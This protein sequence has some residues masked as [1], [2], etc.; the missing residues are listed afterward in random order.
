MT[1]P[2]E[3]RPKQQIPGY[4]LLSKL[5]SGA[6]ASV[7]KARQ[8]SLDRIVAI[9]VLPR[10]STADPSF[11]ERFY[12]EGRVAAKLNHPN[13]VGALD[14]GKAGDLHYFVMEY[15]EG[16]TVYDELMEN[17]L[18]DET[19]AV[20]IVLEIA[21]A[22]DHAHKAG[23]IHRDVKPQNIIIT[24]DGTA[25]LADMG[26]AREVGAQVNEDEAGKAVGSPYYM[27]PEQVVSDPRLDFRT[28]LYSIGA[29]FYFMVTG[30]V[31]FD[32]PTPKE[33]MQMHLND[34]LTPP[35]KAN[36]KVS[37][38][39]SEVIQVCMA[40]DPADRYDT[41]ADLVEDLEAI[42]AGEAPLKAQLKLGLNMDDDLG[43]MTPPPATRPES[44]M[45][46]PAKPKPTPAAN[47][48]PPTLPV[49]LHHQPMFW[50]AA[51][52]W[53]SAAVF[54]TLWWLK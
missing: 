37:Q 17:V 18:Y 38:E 13:I 28:D 20:R 34:D 22:L 12:A 43:D 26:L 32:A 47:R 48:K 36:A 31:P 19:D 52:G 45:S 51:A 53:V 44:P 9:K 10:R 4:Q 15:V 25:K 7:Y 30:K 3:S 16:T 49:P 33:V 39:V 5:G 27:S 2:P 40:K 23:L 1:Q 14:V 24:A 11:V 35:R 6:M 54:A 21:R 50:L 42:Q 29:T 41:A 46:A 8:L